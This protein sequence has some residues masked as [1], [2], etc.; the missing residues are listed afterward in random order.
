MSEAAKK[1]L[2]EA[3]RLS[4][5][6]RSQLAKQLLDSVAAANDAMEPEEL[7]EYP[8]V[9]ASFTEALHALDQDRAF[10]TEGGVF[11]DDAIDA[12]IELKKAEIEAV[13]MVTHPKEFEL[14]Y[15]V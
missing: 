1:I 7:A 13:M 4:V 15:S 8:T 3:L 6:E 11:T 12:Y 5:D 10:L 14:Y 9:C 2:E